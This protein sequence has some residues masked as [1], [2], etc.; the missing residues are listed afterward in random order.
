MRPHKLGT[1]GTKL[2]STVDAK[3]SESGHTPGFSWCAVYSIGKEKN[4]TE[5]CVWNSRNICLGL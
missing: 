3:I 5:A 2:R 1:I 4:K